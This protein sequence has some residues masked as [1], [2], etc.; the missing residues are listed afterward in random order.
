[1]KPAGS[2]TH[3]GA[4]KVTTLADVIGRPPSRRVPQ[5][6]ICLADDQPLKNGICVDRAACEERQPPLIPAEEL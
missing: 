3:P 4:P 2:V 6:R 5:C 1:M